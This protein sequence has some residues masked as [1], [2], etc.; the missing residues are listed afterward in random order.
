MSATYLLDLDRDLPADRI[1]VEPWMV[2]RL[3]E[4]EAQLR[5]LR[6]Q[7]ERRLVEGQE[8]LCAQCRRPIV[9]RTDRKFCSNRCRQAAH[10]GK[11]RADT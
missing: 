5:R 11:W 2:D 6:L 10:R 4:G 9:G 3:R 8:Q 1:T 7:I